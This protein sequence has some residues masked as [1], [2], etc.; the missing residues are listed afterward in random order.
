MIEK[1]KFTDIRIGSGFDFHRLRENRKL[2][3][4]GTEIPF[5]KGLLGHSDADVV[6]HAVMDAILGASAMGDIGKL[7]PDS[8][9]RFRDISSMILLARIAELIAAN[10][11]VVGNLDVTVIAQRPRIA[12]YSGE[13]KKNIAGRLG[14][15]ENRVSIKGTT[16]EGMGITGREEGIAAEAV[17]LLLRSHGTG[18]I[19]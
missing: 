16:T 8:D 5:E 18:T 1:E 10:G 9:E 4:G 2:I 14:I 19:E 7:F 15:S 6:I 13:M 12:P 17:C 3:L 11:Y